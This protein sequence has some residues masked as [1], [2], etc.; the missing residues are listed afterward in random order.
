MRTAEF[1]VVYQ[2]LRAGVILQA[3][4]SCNAAVEVTVHGGT[5]VRC[6]DM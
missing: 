1:F 5:C 3:A 2:A 4:P 6:L